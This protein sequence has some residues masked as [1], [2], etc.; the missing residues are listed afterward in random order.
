[1]TRILAPLPLVLTAALSGCLFPSGLCENETRDITINAVLAA[2]GAGGGTGTATLELFEARKDQGSAS[3]EQSVVF[4]AASTLDRTTVT[5]VHLH[6]GT[7]AAPGQVLYEF[8][9]V[10]AGAP[11][12]ITVVYLREPYRGTVAFPDL[13]AAMT[14]SATY[15]DVHV[16]GSAI[17]AL[18]GV[19]RV[20]EPSAA[21]WNRDYC[22]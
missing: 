11:S 16:G 10:P 21:L 1:M 3:V 8:P 17:P 19:S 22:S 13:F 14:G 6:A 2:P 7:P 15:L 12:N 9:L 4:A 18:A 20:L 5:A